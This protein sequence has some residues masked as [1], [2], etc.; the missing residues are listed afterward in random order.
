[1]QKSI[2]IGGRMVVP[3]GCAVC[4]GQL[5]ATLKC[6]RPS[7]GKQWASKDDLDEA[8]EFVE[9]IAKIMQKPPIDGSEK[10]V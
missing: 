2:Y 1:M 6:Q 9:K 5:S 8:Y 4:G 7:C 10:V 3:G